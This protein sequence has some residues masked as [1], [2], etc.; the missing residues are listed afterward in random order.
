MPSSSVT[1]NRPP[2]FSISRGCSPT[3][4]RKA[5]TVFLLLKTTNW[6]LAGARYTENMTSER[7]RLQALV[8]DR[9]Q[10]IIDLNHRCHSA[11]AFFLQEST[12]LFNCVVNANWLVRH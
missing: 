1:M 2:F 8:C 9:N 4:G 6:A 3:S 12:L 10:T 5:A 11:S 7:R